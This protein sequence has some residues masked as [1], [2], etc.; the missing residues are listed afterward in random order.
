MNSAHTSDISLAVTGSGGAGAITAGELLLSLAGKNDCFG[1]MRR[2][3]GPQIRG[4][5]AAALVRIS[6]VPVECMNDSFDLL[7]ALDWRN[8]ERFAGE[9]AL[10]SDSLI[11]ADPAAG[12]IPAAIRELDIEIIEV[13]MKA[14]AKD[15]PA[16]R[17]NMIALGLLS[18]WLGFCSDEAGKLIGEIFRNK[19]E[20]IVSGSRAAFTAGFTEPLI[21]E[22]REARPRPQRG[23]PVFTGSRWHFNGNQGC[24]LGA[25]RG[26]IRF[27]AAYPITPASDLLEW[28]SPRLEQLGG[29]LLQ[30]EDELASINMVIGA[31]F[32][33]VPAMTAT[34]GPGLALMTEAMGLAVASETPAVVINVMRGGPSTGIP[35]KSEQADLNMALYGL[36]GDAPH[37]VLGALDHA[38]CIL[39]T[40]WS[41]RLAEVLQTVAVVL[42]DQ[43][44]AQSTVLI[45]EPE[46]QLPEISNR[47]TA[48]A[49]EGYRR[50]EVT[51]SGVS[52]MAIPGTSWSTYVADGLEHAQSGKPSTAAADHLA[53]LDKRSHKISSF[54]Y[55]EHW[56]D[57]GGDGETAILT[58]G[59]TTAA[60]REAAA[61]LR[62]G[63]QN[64]KVIALRLLLPAS[65]DKLA[66]ELEGVKQVLIVEQ[67]HS[68]QF[69]LYLRAHYDIQAVTRTLARPG[70]LP[71]TP[72]EIVKHIENWS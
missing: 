53:Q 38:D 30:A 15:I 21:V 55:G 66:R 41:V 60:V 65:P 58:W 44:L 39:T 23:E 68:R 51:D 52:P 72:A 43:N 24:G 49:D 71:I 31:S 14:L 26:G 10:R 57:V 1:M 69:C 11:I 56:A 4:G 7:L 40:E 9:I 2:S 59:S 16:G 8:A 34:S 17:P 22:A 36:H 48:Q 13:P 33:G 27:A 54:D 37:L 12:E 29:S 46:Y 19:G 35:T 50:Y 20:Q 18:H 28:L 64:V 67:S 62:A 47:V 63:G 42:T 6:H 45:P 70:P 3:F 25:I 61:R 5:E 32:G